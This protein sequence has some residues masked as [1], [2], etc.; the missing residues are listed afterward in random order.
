MKGDWNEIEKILAGCDKKIERINSDHTYTIKAAGLIVDG[1][2]AILKHTDG[3]LHL[4]FSTPQIQSQDERRRF[5]A[6]RTLISLVSDDE[7][8]LIDFGSFSHIS[9]AL[10]QDYDCTLRQYRNNKFPSSNAQ[11]HRLFVPSNQELKTAGF[12][13]TRA[14]R[15]G[16]TVFANG[17]V[18]ID[19]D[20]YK[21]HLF[22]YSEKKENKH[23]LIIDS[24]ETISSEKFLKCSEAIQL[25]YA[26]ISG[27]LPRDHRYFFTAGEPSFE[28]P[29]G[30]SFDTPKRSFYSNYS[31]VPETIY[32]H[33][34]GVRKAQ[35]IPKA[36]FDRLCTA[37]L[38]DTGFRRTISL[39]VEGNTLSPELRAAT[40]SVALE[41]MTTVLSERFKTKLTPIKDKALAKEI[42]KS[43]KL[44]FSKY[45]DRLDTD[46]FNSIQGKLNYINT[47]TNKDKLLLPFE[48]LGV[49]LPQ[50]DK[51]C[52]EKR[53]DFLHG[54]MPLDESNKEASGFTLEQIVLSLHFSI[55]CL[56]LK[57]IGYSGYATYYPAV[58]EFNKKI[59]LS[60][61][62]I[63]VI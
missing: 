58:N 2:K 54:R 36:I 15:V 4:Y 27:S 12:I 14:L 40:Y 30:V 10:F 45:R 29:D 38:T 53:N 16:S 7:T 33:L 22:P 55:N 37:T 32:Q 50:K 9:L 31:P 57:S 43:L 17:I 3:K 5:Q 49:H 24:T 25:A 59:K 26:F 1:Q 20:G 39:V 13:E 51:V 19:L 8:I 47:P 6:D 34:F 18:Q 42:V 63:R 62:P 41:A 56:I 48:I 23:F 52:I 11:F 44:S 46:S 35:Q 28:K 60:E 61:H 21:F